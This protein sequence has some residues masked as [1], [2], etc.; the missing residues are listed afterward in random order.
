MQRCRNAR[1][2]LIFAKTSQDAG[3]LSRALHQ[4]RTPIAAPP[5]PS[6]APARTGPVSR[7]PTSM[8]ATAMNDRA[9]RQRASFHRSCSPIMHHA[10]ALALRTDSFPN[11]IQVRPRIDRHAIIRI[12]ACAREC[13][14]IATRSVFTRPRSSRTCTTYLRQYCLHL[15]QSNALI[16]ATQS[17]SF[18]LDD[19]VSPSVP[20]EGSETRPV[21]V[22]CPKQNSNRRAGHIAL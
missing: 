3:R 15:R 4:L 17:S 19:S 18:A 10:S 11:L 2:Q 20:T 12:F 14:H 16:R 1:P 5:P 8:T 21:S 6:I 7:Q 9:T 22:H 13:D